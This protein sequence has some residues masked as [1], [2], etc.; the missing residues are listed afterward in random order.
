MGTLG[1]EDRAYALGSADQVG[2]A[3]HVYDVV[4]IARAAASRERAR[5]LG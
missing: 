3:V 1:G 2:V 4:E 5:L